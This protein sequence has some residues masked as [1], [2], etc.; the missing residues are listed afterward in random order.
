MRCC[1]LVRQGVYKGT[2]LSSLYRSTFCLVHSPAQT[3]VRYVGVFTDGGADGALR[4]YG[5]DNMSVP[6]PLL[7]CRCTGTS[8]FCWLYIID[9]LW[10]REGVTDCMCAGSHQTAGR[11]TAA[12][13]RPT[14]TPLACFWCASLPRWVFFIKQGGYVWRLCFAIW[15]QTLPYG[16]KQCDELSL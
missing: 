13:A 9:T 14:S 8:C 15:T 12:R 5:V 2:A 1:A 7:H 11:A 3:P 16:P 4:Q 10:L 6:V